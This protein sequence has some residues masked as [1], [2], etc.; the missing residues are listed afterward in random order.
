MGMEAI[1]GA[2]QGAVLGFSYIENADAGLT[3]TLMRL[4][5]AVG[6]TAA[7]FAMGGPLGAAI[8]LGS[9]LVLGH[10]INKVEKKSG[11]DKEIAQGITDAVA[12]AK[13]DNYYTEKPGPHQGDPPKT[14]YEGFRDGIEGIAT[15]TAAGMREGFKAGFAGGK[16]AVDGFVEGAKGIVSGIIGG[17]TGK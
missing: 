3:R 4:E 17:V 2:I 12:Y 9:G 16:G 15:G 6:G 13:Q 11:T 7:G 5:T 1:D 10:I 8:G 14:M